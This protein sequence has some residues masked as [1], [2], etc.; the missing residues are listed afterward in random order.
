VSQAT[1]LIALASAAWTFPMVNAYP[2]FVEPIP[3]ERRGVLTAL[4]LLCAALG[5]GIGDPMN[6]ALFDLFGTYRPLF[7]MMATY[8]A[9]A[10][11]AVLA[12]PRGAGEAAPVRDTAGRRAPGGRIVSGESA[13]S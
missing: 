3:R 4:F 7:L 6:G 12:V 2:L 9:F 1:P 10:F 5:G 13:I 8:T 11:V